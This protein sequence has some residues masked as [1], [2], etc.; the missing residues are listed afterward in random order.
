MTTHGKCCLP[1]KLIRDSVP[2][3]FTE[4][5][6]CRYP[7]PNTYQNSRLPKEKQV[8][9]INYTGCPNSL[10]T[11]SH[12]CQFCEWWELFPNHSSQTPG[13]GQP[14]KEN[15]TRIRK[16]T[17]AMLILSYMTL[18]SFNLAG[19]SMN[20]AQQSSATSVYPGPQEA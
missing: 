16:L 9:S 11:M 18:L 4:D 6:S 17:P 7:L 13:K 8:F 15:F 2:K 12:S 3:V 5:W 20:Q 19:T 14:C 1:K 10:G